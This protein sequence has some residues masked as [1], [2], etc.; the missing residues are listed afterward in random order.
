LD[1][2]TKL[3]VWT[4]RATKDLEKTAQFYL[5]LYGK[6]KALNI[7]TQ[8]RKSTEI[9]EKH[10][11]D[12]SKIGAKDENFA[13]LKRNYRKLIS[14]NCKITYRVGKQYIY[15]IRVFDT[16]QNPSKNK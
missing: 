4:S 3:V 11:G 8:I 5:E 7:L 6:E 14:H 2:V 16:R 1:E 12:F 9:L 15:V 10:C 13:H